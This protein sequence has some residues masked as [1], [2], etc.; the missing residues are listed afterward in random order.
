MRARLAFAMSAA[1]TRGVLT[2]AHRSRLA[3][4]CDIL[5]PVPLESFSD[6]RADALLDAAHILLTGWGCPA[7]DARVLD[8]APRLRLIAHAAG[9]VKTFLSPDVF[10]RGIAVTHA[11]DANAIPVAEYTL[12]AILFANKRVLAFRQ[13][14]AEQRNAPIHLAGAPVGN[15]GKTV[16]IVGASRIGRLVLDLLRRHDLRVLLHDPFLSR[17]QAA[18]LGAELMELDAM[19][20]ELDVLSLH[21]PSLPS[22]RHMIDAGRLAMLRDGAT[23]INTARG[24][25]IDQAALETE[26]VSGRL[27]AFLDV[28]EPEVLPRESPFYEL[29]NV[30]LT[31]HIAGALG[32]EQARLGDFAVGD[33]ERFLRDEPMRGLITEERFPLLA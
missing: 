31:P 24:A 28:T 3:A 18:T 10:A 2:D 33:I 7:I 4:L 9:T 5:D 13:S 25:L 14:Y 19:L 15:L 12:A 17:Q 1:G 8:R 30:V 16:G 21:A 20:P 6:P 32:T 27:S 26:L 11:A 22:T 23:L 29:P